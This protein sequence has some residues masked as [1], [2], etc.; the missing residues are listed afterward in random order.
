MVNFVFDILF[1]LV[2]I[3]FVR[4]LVVRS[5]WIRFIDGFVGDIIC[6]FRKF[7]EGVL[8]VVLL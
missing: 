7:L 6:V 3:L 4:V 8:F 2:V 1:L 5:F